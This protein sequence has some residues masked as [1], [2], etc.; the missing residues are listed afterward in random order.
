MDVYGFTMFIQPQNSWISIFL[1]AMVGSPPPTRQPWILHYQRNSQPWLFVVVWGFQVVNSWTKF[2]DKV[3]SHKLVLISMELVRYIDH[4]AS[5]F[6]VIPIATVLN[7][8]LC[9]LVKSHFF[10]AIFPCEMYSL[11]RRSGL[12]GDVEA[13]GA[14]KWMWKNLWRNPIYG[15]FH[16]GGYRDTHQMDDL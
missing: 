11:I 15:S 13:S 9:F 2:R 6:V 1:V 8:S 14:A 4:N 12:R 7:E 5:S 16:K 3:P 10:L